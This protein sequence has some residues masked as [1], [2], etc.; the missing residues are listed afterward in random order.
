MNFTTNPL[1]FWTRAV[2]RRDAI[3]LNLRY[4]IFIDSFIIRAYFGDFCFKYYSVVLFGQKKLQ[5]VGIITVFQ[6]KKSQNR[7]FTKTEILEDLEAPMLPAW[8]MTLENDQTEPIDYKLWIFKFR[9]EGK[10]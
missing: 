4:F 6:S 5:I 1:L 10:I 8:L 9:S 3:A 2:I 7:L